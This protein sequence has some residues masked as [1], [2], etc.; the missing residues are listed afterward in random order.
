[1]KHQRPGQVAV[2]LVY[3]R[4]G[5][6]TV[7]NWP[8]Y[9]R[10]QGLSPRGRGNRVELALV[11]ALPGS[12]PAWAGEPCRTGPCTSAPRVYPRVGGGT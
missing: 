7:S 8:L 12:I 6:G 5:G 9:Q 2:V 3:P 11:P 4:V 10:S 1:M